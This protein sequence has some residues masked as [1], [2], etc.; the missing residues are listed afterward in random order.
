[1]TSDFFWGDGRVDDMVPGDYLK[2][3]MNKFKENSSSDF[4]A[5]RLSNGFATNSKAEAWFDALPAATQGDWKLL[6]A[7]FLTQWPKETV[8]ALSTEQH[9]A[10]LRTEKLRKEDIGKVVT[11]RGLET[12]G[13]SA[14]ASRVL[15]LSALADDP[16]GAM[17]HEVREA[18]PAILKKILAG[19]FKSWKLFCDAVKAVDEDTI[20]AAMA[21]EHRLSSV[22]AETRR[23]R[24]ELARHVM[25]ESPTGPLRAAFGNFA[26][27]HGAPPLRAQTPVSAIQDPFRGGIMRGGNI[28][29][30]YQR[31]GGPARGGGFRANHLRMADLTRNTS[32]L[33]QHADTPAG[34]VAYQLQVQAWK[35]ANPTKL[36]GGDEFAP[37]PLTPGTDAVGTGECFDCGV[38]HAIGAAH[39]RAI[40]D[41]GETTYR[42][43]ANQIIREDRQ[44][45]N[46]ANAVGAPAN[47]NL[48]Q[49]EVTADYPA[50]WVVSETFDQGNG[51]GPGV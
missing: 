44:A 21:D 7:A 38:R 35:T 49:V 20:A 50:H 32:G 5:E 13:Q 46:L 33:I 48:V 8:P 11:V 47:V 51:D 19:S 9:R 18:M 26:V 42:R 45:T 31:G 1:M 3:T 29:R 22:K 40:V 2:L 37:Y 43:I 28:F 17:I 30:G 12:T 6:K 4:K 27:D 36:N 23:L 24:E 41:T 16:S 15:A 39:V 25:P 14:W 34:H 10:R